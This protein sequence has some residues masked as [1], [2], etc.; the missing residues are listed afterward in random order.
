MPIINKKNKIMLAISAID[1]SKLFSTT[2][3]IEYRR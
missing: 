2:T 3:I 1:K